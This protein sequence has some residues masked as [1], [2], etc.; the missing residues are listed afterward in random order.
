MGEVL[1]VAFAALTARVRGRPIGDVIRTV[2]PVV[3]TSAPV[4]APIVA[5]LAF[6]YVRVSPWTLVLFLVPAMA[7]QRLYAPV[8][9]SNASSRSICRTPTKRSSARTFSSRLP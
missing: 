7:A 9:E 5:L 8:P 1:D 6:M 4:Y 2:V 3:L